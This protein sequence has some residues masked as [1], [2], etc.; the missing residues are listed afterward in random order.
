MST[1]AAQGRDGWVHGDGTPVPHDMW[2]GIEPRNLD[3][4]EEC[5]AVSRV[6][7]KFHDILCALVVSFFKPLCETDVKEITYAM[8]NS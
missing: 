3:A 7:F 1:P 8:I 4:T 6:S 5:A 2:D